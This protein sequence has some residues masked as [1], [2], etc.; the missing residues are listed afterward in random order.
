[1][2]LDTVKLNPKNISSELETIKTNNLFK[3][4]NLIHFLCRCASL[5]DQKETDQHI[6]I[7]SEFKDGIDSYQTSNKK[8]KCDDSINHICGERQHSR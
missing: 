5:F 6:L 7:T 1:M 2:G 4:S 8:T 3:S